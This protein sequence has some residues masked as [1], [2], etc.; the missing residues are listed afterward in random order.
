M[1]YGMLSTRISHDG[2]EYVMGQAKRTCWNN[3]CIVC[4]QCKMCHCIQPSYANVPVLRIVSS[5]NVH[6]IAKTLTIN[7]KIPY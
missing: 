6:L 7:L 5:L 4:F 2:R 1:N 3:T